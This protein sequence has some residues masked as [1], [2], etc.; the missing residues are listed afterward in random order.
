[1]SPPILWRPSDEVASRATIAIYMTWLREKRGLAFADYG[2]LWRWSV[3][4]LEAFWQSIWEFFE[5][6]AT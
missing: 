1:M 6:E 4:D 3:D 5:V 2:E